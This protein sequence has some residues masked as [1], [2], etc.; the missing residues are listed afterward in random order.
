MK[1]VNRRGFAR[2]IAGLGAAVLVG[3][4]ADSVAAD[5]PLV[6][7][8]SAQA[9]ALGYTHD[10]QTVDTEKYSNFKADSSCANCQLYLGGETSGGCG[11][12][13]GQQVAAKGWCSAWA[14]KV[15]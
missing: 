2:V 6:D 1:S 3:R 4:T 7:A 9:K 12:F 8:D 13:P 10:A 5:T 15:S 11:I 14:K